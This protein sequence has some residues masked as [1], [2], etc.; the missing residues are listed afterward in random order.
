VKSRS[1]SKEQRRACWRL[2]AEILRYRNIYIIQ[3]LFIKLRISCRNAAMMM[4]P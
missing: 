1:G 4:M 2:P 3:S